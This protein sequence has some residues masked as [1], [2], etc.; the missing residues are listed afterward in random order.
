MT[1]LAVLLTPFLDLTFA[2][3]DE[4]PPL[5]G[6]RFATDLIRS[7]GGGAITATGAA[8]LGLD[9]VLA[10]PLGEDPSGDVPGDRAARR[11]RPAGRA[12]RWPDRHD[13]RACRRTATARW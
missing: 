7:P 11:R 3:L 13:G 8:R 9:T 6:E 10:A 2:G 5:G 12:A 1:D 4:L